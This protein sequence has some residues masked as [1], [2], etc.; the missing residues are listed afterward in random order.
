[1]VRYHALR[2]PTSI[3]RKTPCYVPE[4]QNVC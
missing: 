3:R 1:V 2:V 4:S